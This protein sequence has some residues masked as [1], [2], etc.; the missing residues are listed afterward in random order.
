MKGLQ[1]LSC[2]G[3]LG[4]LVLF[5]LEKRRLRE[6]LFKVL[7]YLMGGCNEDGT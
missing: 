6:K 5:I 1:Y 4:E 3:R 2:E 7:K